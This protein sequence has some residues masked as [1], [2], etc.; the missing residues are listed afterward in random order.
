MSISHE[1][2]HL[3]EHIFKNKMI[4]TWEVHIKLILP[5]NIFLYK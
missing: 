4:K 5:Q 2:N 3:D 1:S